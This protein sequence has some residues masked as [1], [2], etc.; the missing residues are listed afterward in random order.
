MI[1]SSGLNLTCE[2]LL[3]GM[4][5]EGL[6]DFQIEAHSRLYFLT[7]LRPEVKVVT[8]LHLISRIRL[9]T[10]SPSRSVSLLRRS[11]GGR[12]SASEVTFAP[13]VGSWRRGQVGGLP[14]GRCGRIDMCRILICVARKY[15]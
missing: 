6:G 5:A 9:A 14:D 4:R 3:L 1:S 13:K 8:H 11:Q 15:L 10:Q 7:D 12:G 2:G